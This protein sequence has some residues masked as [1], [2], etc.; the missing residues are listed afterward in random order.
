MKSNGQDGLRAT[1]L[2]CEPPNR[3]A[4]FTIGS[5]PIAKTNRIMVLGSGTVDAVPV[6]A[7][8]IAK[9]PSFRAAPGP[10]LTIVD[11]KVERML[12]VDPSFNVIEVGLNV[13]VKVAS[14][15][16][17]LEPPMAMVPPLK[18]SPS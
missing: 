3:V 15:G 11:V 14:V 10:E 8:M 9:S 5:R 13:P 7:L 16:L 12:S 1:N 17:G 6:V 4:L 18:D 2:Y